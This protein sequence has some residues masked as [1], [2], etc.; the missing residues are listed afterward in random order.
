M[1]TTRTPLTDIEHE[2]LARHATASLGLEP[3]LLRLLTAVHEAGHAIV[4]SALGFDVTAIKVSSRDVLGLHNNDH[5]SL[6]LHEGQEIRLPDELSLYMAG[7]QAACFWL[8]G[9]GIR[10][11]DP[12]LPYKTALNT[13]AGGDINK[14]HALCDRWGVPAIATTNEG[15][16]GAAHILKYRWRAVLQLAY[17]VNR[18]GYLWGS[19]LQPYLDADPSAQ[20]ASLTAYGRWMTATAALWALPCAEAAPT[21]G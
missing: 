12:N 7:F 2:A 15:V 1:A 19:D 11:M 10:A 21:P 14:C 16:R 4:G 13:L 6:E 9:R 5:I 3:R 18:V 20:R 8:N 17:T